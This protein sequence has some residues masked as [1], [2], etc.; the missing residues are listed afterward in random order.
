MKVWHLNEQEP[1]AA[2][3]ERDGW[4]RETGER[5]RGGQIVDRGKVHYLNQLKDQEGYQRKLY[6]SLLITE[7]QAGP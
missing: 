4:N 1:T 5:G 7:S 2:L 6:T 3:K